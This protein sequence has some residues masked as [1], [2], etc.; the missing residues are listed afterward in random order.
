MNKYWIY[1]MTNSHHNVL[2]IGVTNN[3]YRRVLEHKRHKVK[4]FTER[5]NCDLLVYYAE[6]NQI[7]EAIAREKQLK[8]WQR[9]W[10]DTLVCQFNPDWCDL[11]DDWDTSSTL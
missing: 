8:N 4:G 1:I 9:A 5:Y 10:K 3:L 7:D 6:F 11:A 2:Y